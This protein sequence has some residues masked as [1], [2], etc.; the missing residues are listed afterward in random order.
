MNSASQNFPHHLGVLRSRMLH[1]TDYELA[2]NYFLEEFAGDATFVR[3]SEPEQM[4]HLVSV[5]GIVVSKAV[6]RRV[7]VENALVSY[8]REHR[9]VHGNA[10]AD[11]RIVF[12]FY[13]EDAD[14]GLLMLI[15]GIRGQMEVAR[16]HLKSGLPDPRWN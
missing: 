9:F 4:P 16:F 6:G 15:P 8:L 7:E 10:R 11:G 5:L 13:F 1:P 14:S 3:A 12:F 2:V